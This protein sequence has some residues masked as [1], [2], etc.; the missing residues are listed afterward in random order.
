MNAADLLLS[1]VAGALVVIS[2]GLHA[3]FL[4]FARL[5][6]SALLARL[7]LAAYLVLVVCAFV[8]ANSL[9]LSV[10]WY[11]VIAVMLVGYWFAPK[12]IW[13][14]TVATHTAEPER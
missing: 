14:L 9:D 4:A 12:A 5:R 7:S 2:G 1:V 11:A 6:R 3:L 8:L 10:A 13:H